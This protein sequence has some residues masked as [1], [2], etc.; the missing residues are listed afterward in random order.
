MFWRKNIL[1]FSCVYNKKKLVIFEKK[2]MYFTKI[3]FFLF[4]E[5]RFFHL[6]LLKYGIQFFVFSTFFSLILFFLAIKIVR[7]ISQ[8]FHFVV[9]IFN[10]FE[11]KKYF[12]FFFHK[13]EQNKHMLLFLAQHKKQS[14]VCFSKNKQNKKILQ[15]RETEESSLFTEKNFEKQ[16]LVMFI[17]KGNSELSRVSILFK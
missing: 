12:Q 8:L 3:D 11:Q 14:Y 13:E 16:I 15:R 7:S 9:F 2:F 10:F 17:K 1:F 4:S 6:Y 5:N